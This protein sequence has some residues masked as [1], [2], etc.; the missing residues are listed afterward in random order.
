MNN[1]LVGKRKQKSVWLDE[2]MIDLVATYSEKHNLNFSP[3]IESLALLG[4]QDTKAVGNAWMAF[5]IAGGSKDAL[6]AHRQKATLELAAELREC[7]RGLT[8]IVLALAATERQIPF[9]DDDTHYWNA[10]TEASGVATGRQS[11]VVE[12]LLEALDNSMRTA[13]QA[14]LQDIYTE[15]REDD[16]WAT[17]I[18]EQFRAEVQQNATEVG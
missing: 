9:D 6:G 4:L 11:L 8:R 2:G 18:L 5:N 10:L 17:A 14:R 12:Q 13:A 16:A 1:V 7:M 15:Q 3:A